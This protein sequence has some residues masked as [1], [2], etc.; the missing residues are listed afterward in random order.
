MAGMTDIALI[1]PFLLPLLG[2]GALLF[3]GEGSRYR[4][5]AP[6]PALSVGSIF[7]V[8]VLLSERSF[9]PRSLNLQAA[10][11]GQVFD[12]VKRKS[13]RVV[14][15]EG[16]VTGEHTGRSFRIGDRVRVIVTR[17]DIARRQIDFDLD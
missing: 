13:V 11:L 7:A 16:D 2:A 9:E 15:T 12:E 6:L 4:D 5:Y 8:A 14:E 10:F 1:V 17:A 3:L